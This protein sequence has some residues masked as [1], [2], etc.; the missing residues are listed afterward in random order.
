MCDHSKYVYNKYLHKTIFVS[1]GKC[2]ACL[3]EKANARALRIRNHNDGKLCLFIM[4][5]YD[6]R[7]V[8]YVSVESVLN[9]H[10]SSFDELGRSSGSISVYRDFDVRHYRDKKIITKNLKLLTTFPASAFRS[11]C[12]DIPVLR[13]KSGCVGVILWSD[14]QNFIKRLRINLE[15]NGINNKITYFAVG[16]YGSKKKSWRPHFHLLVYFEEGSFETLQSV[17]VK[18]WP[19]G[20]MLKSD[21]RIQVAVDA[22][23]YVAS[24]VN[25]SADLPNILA[26]NPIRQKHSHS[27]FFGSNVH[28][29][30]LPS[31]LE[32]ADRHDMSY[33]REVLENGTPVFRNLP[34][35]KY[36]ISRY[37]PRFKGDFSLSPSEICELLRFPIKLWYKFGDI[38][39]N[40]KLIAKEFMYSKEDFRRFV[41]HLR[42]CVDYYIKVTGKTLYDYS[43]DYL[44]VWFER[45][46]FVFKHSYDA[47][48]QLC[49]F[50]EFYENAFEFYDN[51]TIAPT[52]PHPSMMWYQL[53]PCERRDIK[54]KVFNLT[55]LYNKRQNLKEINSIVI[56]ENDGY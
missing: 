17:I 53:N 1:C 39:S 27:L 49:D 13:K 52:L 4:L 36:V 3:Q 25:K 48:T 6:N 43:I 16:E 15:R 54:I 23:G 34:V 2:E 8:P 33:C 51:P 21:K 18:S 9:I 24:Y 29:F 5:S 12:Y 47:I 22:S 7:F 38:A 14:V 42:H 55:D 31:I 10:P 37:F 11:Y 35:P 41:V 45:W 20:D 30:T 28:G 56:E 26:S 50:A 40:Q 19:Y 32:K 44:R 46:S